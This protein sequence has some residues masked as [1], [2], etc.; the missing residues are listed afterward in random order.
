MDN[1]TT[2][3]ATVAWPRH[4]VI[5]EAK[6]IEESTLLS[7][8]GHFAAAH[9]WG[10]CNL[11][12]GVG[13]SVL[14]AVAAA[15]TFSSTWPVAVGVL[16][17]LVVVMSAV[18]TFLNPND[19][20]TKHLNAGNSYEAIS[21]RARMFWSIDCWTDGVD[22][23]AT[24][25]QLKQLSGDRSRLNLE[26]PQ[27]SPWAYRRAKKGIAEGEAAYE[28]DKP[29]ANPSSEL[30][31]ALASGSGRLPEKLAQSSVPVSPPR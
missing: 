13:I 22:S 12:F 10:S 11:I 4:E 7:A 28:V 27:I 19:R 1:L 3:E 20:A 17:L 8:K 31:P 14:S 29:S 24:T 21:S 23:R 2:T 18:V 15:F 26:S 16:S 25:D 9:L 5:K 6:R 30:G